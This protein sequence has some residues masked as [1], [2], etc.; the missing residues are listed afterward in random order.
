MDNLELAKNSILFKDLEQQDFRALLHCL[1]IQIK[2][3]KRGDVIE[4]EGNPAKFA[5]LVLKGKCKTTHID[6]DGSLIPG[7]IYIKD[8]IYGLEYI[9]FAKSNYE[10]ELVAI[11]DSTLLIMN[12][13]RLLT[14]CENRCFRHYHLISKCL[15]E[16]SRLITKSKERITELSQ[17]KMR[18]KILIY[19]KNNIPSANQ[20]YKIPYNRQ[21][22][23]DYL[24]VERT[25][26]SSQLSKL[27]K[28]GLIDYKR[29]EFMLKK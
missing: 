12:L 21:E 14:P 17:A 27:K 13:F 23:A 24:G 25:A 15:D 22:L 3:Y 18:D 20:F 19:L 26:L 11:E 29:S 2:K 16:Y 28:E 6:V 1:S 10:E 9:H 8:Q 4:H 7:T 5:Y